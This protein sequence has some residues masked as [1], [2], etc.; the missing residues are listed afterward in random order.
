[1]I[2]NEF[3]TVEKVDSVAVWL[4][5]VKIDDDEKDEVIEFGHKFF[6]ET[7][8][9]AFCI[10]VHCSQG[11]SI[12]EAYSIWEWEKF[13]KKMKYTA[14]TRARRYNDINLI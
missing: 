1:L 4:K 14:I 13:S 2:N 6:L 10:T 11:L 5:R 7:F 9:L 3:L 8:E 12:D